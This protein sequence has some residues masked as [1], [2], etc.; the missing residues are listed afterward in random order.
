MNHER[1]PPTNL[2][3]VLSLLLR[4]FPFCK[5]LWK[6]LW[7]LLAG[8][9][10]AGV[11]TG[12]VGMVIS[13]IWWDSALGES[14][15]SQWQAGLLGIPAATSDMAPALASTRY[16]VALR[17]SFAAAILIPVLVACG[18]A[19]VYYRMWIL[20]R[21][22]QGL[23]LRLFRRLLSRSIKFHAGARVGDAVYRLYQDSA[24]VTQFIDV[25]F[26]V[27]V[28]MTVVFG[29]ATV[30]VALF[31]PALAGALLL[32]WPATLVV[33]KWLSPRLRAGFLRA[34][35]KNSDLT[36]GVQEAYRG[37]RVIK[38]NGLENYTYGALERQSV[39]AFAAAATAR[40]QFAW[41]KVLI[42]W[43]TSLIALLVIFAAT[44][45]TIEHA[46]LAGWDWLSQTPFRDTLAAAGIA[47]WALGSYSA[48]RWILGQGTASV[49]RLYSE[50]G[51]LQD[52]A[53]GLK[54]VFAAL[55][56][57]PEVCDAPDA[58]GLS[59]APT[60]LEARDIW[61]SYEDSN[62]PALKGVSFEARAG[63]VT[64][65]A[66]PTGAGKSTLLSLLLRLLDPDQ[67]SIFVDGRDIRKVSL[68]SLRDNVGAVLQD[69]VV[70]E[71]SIRENITYGTAGCDEERLT[72]AA[73]TAC[74]HE[75]VESLS[76]GYD[77]LLGSRGVRLSAG[78]AQMLAIARAVYRNPGIVVLDEPTSALDARTESKV[79]ES[80]LRW[81]SGRI[82]FV[83][84][85]RLTVVSRADR[86]LFL[87]DGQ[88]VEAGSHE[89][90]SQRVQGS[91]R[92]MMQTAGSAGGPA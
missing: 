90:L 18:M 82:V 42:F 58:T 69:T 2:K 49:N 4:C 81:F 10:V 14:P 38:A 36:A 16:D 8:F 75:L 53:A 62:G 43:M 12:A 17:V 41:F 72:A 1:Q 66:G 74:I 46:Q 89:E 20:Q 25:A 6:H 61:F 70:F 71:A 78:Q 84:S 45:L 44:L 92:A 56:A 29:L 11:L 37:I 23:R 35:E 32:V 33:G 91:Y 7:A 65:V 79:I 50:W 31:H 40:S 19:L 15:L 9:V 64:A 13:V 30:V 57:Q 77:T 80:L 67:G 34:R 86:I 63:T 60:T 24:M 26:L 87:R 48:F 88:V 73:R 21:I 59:G 3:E 83:V 28:G 76:H 22:N 52:M 55:E 5:G 47:T 39:D 51:L 54:R 27:P 68:D 85:H